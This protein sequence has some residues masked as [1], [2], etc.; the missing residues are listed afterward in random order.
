MTRYSLHA[1]LIGL[2]LIATGCQTAYYETMEKFGVHKREILVGRIEKAR[3]DQEATKEQ[4]KSALEQFSAVTNFDGGDLEL[5]Y[6]RLDK[7]LERS[8]ARAKAVH[9]SINDVEHVAEALFIEWETELEQFSSQELRRQSQLQLTE[10]KVR[11]AK[12]LRAMRNAEAK[13]E[14]VLVP[15]RDQVLF[16][17]H[18]LNARA[19][20]SLQN[21]LTSIQSDVSALIKE[22]EKS[23]NEANVFINSLDS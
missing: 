14:P 10:T 3:D 23:I 22:M 4:F 7:E 11:Y 17:K 20:A 12:L 15:F 1:A 6:K 5:H 2:L 18:N 13:I 9:N 21:E 16:L 19:I 8:E